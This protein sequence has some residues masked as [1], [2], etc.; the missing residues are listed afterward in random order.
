[1]NTG[2]MLL[3]LG[4][5]ILL[6]MLTIRVNKN[7][8][9]TEKVV[10]NTKFGV[11]ST[12]LATSI[13][14]EANSKAF[15]KETN[16]TMATSTSELTLPASLGPEAGETYPDFNDFDDFKGFVKIDSTMPSA[17]FTISSTVVYV[18]PSN[19]DS[20]VSTRTW[21]KKIT[22][23]VSSPLMKDTVRLSSI[24]SYWY[25]R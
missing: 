17:I 13:I 9:Q 1:M 8:L 6:S 20:T 2:Q 4:A 22:V 12:S 11:L 3:T 25:F 5:M 23:S 16:D 18:N 19:P 14:E 21:H 15:D 7:N 10:L 24:F